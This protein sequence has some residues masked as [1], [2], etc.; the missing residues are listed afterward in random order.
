M[1]DVNLKVEVVLRN[2]LNK[3]DTMAYTIDVYETPMGYRWYR[4]LQ[5]ILQK[6]QYLEKN[7][8]FLGFPDSP[9]NLDY[10]CQELSW[11]KNQINTFFNNRYHIKETF[12]VDTLR[13]GLEPNQDI[14]NQLHNHFEH[15]QGTVW[16]LK[17]GR[18]HV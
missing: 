8:C 11:A 14:M 7:F 5:D 15:L 2:P 12:N 1:V 17:I 18:A 6:N 13:T 16:G 3:S 4:A 10:I 9:R